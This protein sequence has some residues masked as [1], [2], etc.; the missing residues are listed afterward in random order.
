MSAPGQAPGGLTGRVVRGVSLA[1]GGFI[2]ARGI[3][4]AT[5]VVLA[6]LVTPEELGQFTAGSILVGIGLLFA[7]SGMLAA[8]IHRRD[9]LE[10]AA[11]TAVIATVLAGVLIALLGLAA[12][13]AIGSIFDSDTVAAVAAAMAGVLFLQ[14]AR[15]VPNALLQRRFSFLRRLVVEPASA[16]AFGAGAIIATSNGMGVWGL[17]VGQYAS[18][19]TDLVLSW[20]LVRWRPKLGLASFSMWRE[21]IGYGRHVLAGSAVRRIGDRIPVVA[22]GGF[23][24]NASLG[25]LQY[26]NRIVSTPFAL[27]VAGISYVIFPAFARIS[28]QAG[29]FKPAFLRSLRWT[30]V[31]AM[32]IGLILIA[33]GEPL[34]VLAFGERW[35]EAGE[36]TIALCLFIPAQAIAA[37]TGEGFKG[38][39]R[40]A[41]RTKANVVGVLAGVATMAALLPPF[42]LIGVAIGISVDA[43]ASAAYSVSRTRR[44]LGIAARE[45][46]AVIVAPLLAA[47][48]M[49][50]ALLPLEL[51]VVDAASHGTAAGLLLLAGEGVLGFAL[52][53]LALRILA[54]GLGGELRDLLRRARPR[55]DGRAGGGEDEELLDEETEPVQPI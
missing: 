11:A 38:T 42:G 5:Y 16:V 35:R 19:V 12:S 44:A 10:E 33:L 41:E 8:L 9:R 17:V 14:S 23:I 40:P 28:E 30:T 51:L 50:A 29:R 21:L 7:G 1:G 24:G 18:V 27:L 53:A 20:G 25:Q 36:A 4:L 45:I 46:L 39:G 49:V 3:S 31:V 32:P 22:A 15:V 43:I 6:R 26:A 48:A 54:P 47:V 55:R 34:A 2:L 52:Y 37:V 13:P